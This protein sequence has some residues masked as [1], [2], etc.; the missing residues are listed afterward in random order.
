MKILSWNVRGIGSAQKRAITKGVIT[1]VS[2]NFVFL[3]KTKLV[4]V[5][6]KI[7]KSLWS[8]ISIDWAHTLSTG[9]F[10][11]IIIMWDSLIHY[12]DEVYDGSNSLLVSIRFSDNVMWWILG[13]YGPASRRNRKFFWEELDTL[14]STCNSCWILGGAFNVYRWPMKLHHA[15]HPDSTWENSTHL[16]ERQIL[17]NRDHLITPLL[18]P[19]WETPPLCQNWTDSFIVNNE[20][21]L[22]TNT[23]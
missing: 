12:A 4:L 22:S 14:A 21:A 2:P 13:I 20:R 7:I 23:R 8:S 5:D 16:L 19:I 11:G 15:D 10:R 1:A 9:T 17:W 18:G 3:T 6:K